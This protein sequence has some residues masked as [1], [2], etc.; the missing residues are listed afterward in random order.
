[1]KVSIYNIYILK[2]F[3]EMVKNYQSTNDRWRA[4]SYQKAIAAL[5]RHPKKITSWKVC[6]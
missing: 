5:K 1:M 3:Q 4:I 2:L 6:S